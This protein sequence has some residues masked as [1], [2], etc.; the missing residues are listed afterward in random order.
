MQNV[1]VDREKYI[2]GSDIPIIMGISQF[3]TRFELLLEKAG[4]KEDTFD[5]NEYTEYGN[6]MEPKIRDYINKQLGKSFVEG[7]HIDG[8]IRCHTDG[9]DYTT[10]LEIKTTSQTH[11][12]IDEYKV[13]LV[14]LLFYMEQTNRQTGMLAV[15]DRPEDF[16]ES[17]DEKRLQLF[18][19]RIE[20]YKELIEQINK[21]VDQF[22][23][24][25]E[26]AKENP[27]IAEE[28]LLPDDITELANQVIAFENELSAIKKIEEKW[29]NAKAVLKEKMEAR[30][31]KKWEMPNGTKI[32]LVED[33]PDKEVEVEYYDEEKFIA[34]N[35][36]LHEAYHNKLAEYKETKKEIKKGK[37]GYVKI[38][39]PKEKTNE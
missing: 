28:D 3:K 1:K 7:K 33:T 39:L 22:R 26:K 21:A 23:I 17:F 14:Q 31:I 37:S 25:I 16:N 38:T 6:K 19:I 27:F 15:Y 35:T 4:L 30:C 5:G 2:G 32:T 8:D 36:E 12:T 34:E 13:Y 9:E 18:T 20:N 24:D 29:K 11:N 10:I